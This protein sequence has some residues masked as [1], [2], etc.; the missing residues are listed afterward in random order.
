MQEGDYRPDD[1]EFEEDMDESI[2]ES[3]DE[4][5]MSQGSGSGSHN[6]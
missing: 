2:E 3:F 4:G 6:Y 5:E 1:S